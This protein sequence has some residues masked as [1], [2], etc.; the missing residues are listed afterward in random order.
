L[1][2]NG[3]GTFV[4]TFNNSTDAVKPGMIVTQTGEAA[5]SLVAWPD[6]ANDISTG[7]VGCAPGHDVDTAYTVGDMMPVYMTGSM[8]VVW[9]RLVTGAAAMVAGDLV[10]NSGATAD[11]LA[12]VGTEGLY[13]NL[14][15][16]THWH[17]TI[18]AEQWIKVRL[19]V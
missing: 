8:A 7:V 14:G 5:A 17:N 10:D 9:V 2:A 4:Q 11:G 6:G 3:A 15:R 16:I 12:V 18:A 19:S 1:I 13:E